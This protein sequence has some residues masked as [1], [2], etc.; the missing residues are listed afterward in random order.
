MEDPNGL[1]PMGG[2]TRPPPTAQLQTFN[3]APRSTTRDNLHRPRN[4]G[5]EQPRNLL[6]DM[7]TSRFE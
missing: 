1:K 4:D 5:L 7:G 6:S 2:A 3:A